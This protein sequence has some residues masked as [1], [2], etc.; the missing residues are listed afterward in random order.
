MIA[1]TILNQSKPKFWKR[2]NKKQEIDLKNKTKTKWRKDCKRGGI[3]KTNLFQYLLSRIFLNF[4]SAS[5]GLYINNNTNNEIKWSPNIVHFGKAIA[6]F[7]NCLIRFDWMAKLKK[8][9]ESLGK[10]LLLCFLSQT[11]WYSS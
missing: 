8:I 11:K 3:L 1:S 9:F 7:Y 5:L 2:W 6:V 4:I 10:Y